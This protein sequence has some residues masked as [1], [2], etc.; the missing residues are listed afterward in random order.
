MNLW[1]V[2]AK[3][4]GHNGSRRFH[5]IAYTQVEASRLACAE[6][7]H[8][9]EVTLRLVRDDLPAEQ[10]ELLMRGATN[11]GDWC[12]ECESL[13]AALAQIVERCERPG[14]HVAV[15]DDVKRI[16]RVALARK[17]E[18]MGGSA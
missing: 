1:S 17:G 9:G 3:S 13:G 11:W 5:V 15:R 6:A 7:P 16:A 2:H 8:A 14:L 12:P 18:R 10:R 4:A